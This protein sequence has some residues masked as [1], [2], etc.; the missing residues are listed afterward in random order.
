MKKKTKAKAPKKTSSKTSRVSK[1]PP[2]EQNEMPDLVAALMKLTERIESV[3]RKMDV[4]LSQGTQPQR[5][6]EQSYQS[7]QANP[8]GN[9]SNQGQHSQPRQH[10]P[11]PQHQQ[12]SSQ[13][14]QHSRPQGRP[15]RILHKAVCADCRRECEVPFKPTGERPTYCKECFTKRKTG[16]GSGGG[17]NINRAP[18]PPQT[19]RVVTVKPNGAGKVTVSDFAPSSAPSE[20][21]AKRRK[22]RLAGK[23][24]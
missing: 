23:A 9:Q 7:H 2:A 15:E 11:A 24:R 6:S 13:Q 10:Q 14:H 22:P 18:V 21:P 16:G 19:Q 5:R 4:M 8:G 17:G 12:Q 1:N 3:E 20:S